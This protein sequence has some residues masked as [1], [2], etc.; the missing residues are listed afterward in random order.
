MPDELILI[1]WIIH[2]PLGTSSPSS[3]QR[4]GLASVIVS[5]GGWGQQAQ[6]TV[7]SRL[8][9]AG[10][11]WVEVGPSDDKA[12]MSSSAVKSCFGSRFSNFNS[13]RLSRQHDLIAAGDKSLQHLLEVKAWPV[14]T[15][16]YVR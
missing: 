7:R 1:K 8:E 11:R 13:L 5:R 2:S 6:L 10:G 14:K 15:A 9:S 4:E 3:N 16:L 12:S